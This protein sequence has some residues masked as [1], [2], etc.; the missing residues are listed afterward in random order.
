MGPK[1]SV[2]SV[3]DPFGGSF[4]VI[5]HA[6]ACILLHALPE[7]KT[8]SSSSFSHAPA[9]RDLPQHLPANL[10]L[11]E[12]EPAHRDLLEHEPAY[13]RELLYLNVLTKWGRIET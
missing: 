3:A 7:S 5:F 8:F 11:P 10:V 2:T 9:H 12:N 4:Y 13:F 6:L 1:I